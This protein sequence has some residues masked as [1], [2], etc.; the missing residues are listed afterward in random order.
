MV[1]R[2]GGSTT[3]SQFT[4]HVVGKET[5]LSLVRTT[6]PITRKQTEKRHAAR[7][8]CSHANM[9]MARQPVMMKPLGGDQG[10]KGGSVCVQGITMATML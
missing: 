7:R 9:T 6:T 3:P 1:D 5:G 8:R 2:Q 10:R 4:M